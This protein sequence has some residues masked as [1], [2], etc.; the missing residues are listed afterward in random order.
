MKGKDTFNQISI[1]DIIGN[2]I[3]CN[4]YHTIF[5]KHPCIKLLSY[6]QNSWSDTIIK[7]CKIFMF[8]NDESN[9][10]QVIYK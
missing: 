3:V 2:Y 8:T 4:K 6:R 7:K 1:G 5:H 9:E 10:Y